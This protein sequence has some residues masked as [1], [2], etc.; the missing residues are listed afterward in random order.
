MNFE[1]F[2]AEEEQ[3]KIKA[4]HRKKVIRTYFTL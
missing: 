3:Q 2:D 4:N 1:N